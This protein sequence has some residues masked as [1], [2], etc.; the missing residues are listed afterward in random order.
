MK[1]L[2]INLEEI[3]Q[4]SE[5]KSEENKRFQSFIKSFPNLEIDEKVLKLNDTISKQIDC[6]LCANC[7]KTL[8]PAVT[9][10]ESK[11]LA[12]ELKMDAA[13]FAASFLTADE[14]E[15]INHFKQ[16]P[17][18]FLKEKKCSYYNVRPASCADYPHLTKPNFKYRLRSVMNNYTLCPIVFNVVEQL[19]TE[20]KF[21]PASE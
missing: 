18:I 11:S 20:L 3:K 7:C 10:E 17:C 21:A 4:Q 13:E 14:L 15:N 2:T 19:K 12:K 1:N 5:I 9:H 6:M 16:S 8:H